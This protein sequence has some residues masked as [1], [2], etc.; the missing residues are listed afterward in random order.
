MPYESKAD[1]VVEARMCPRC[2]TML[3]CMELLD[4]SPDIMPDPEDVTITV[5]DVCGYLMAL[6]EDF[7]EREL[8]A[9]ERADIE[10]HPMVAAARRRLM[11]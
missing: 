10:R 2:C 3:N 9:K 11:H 1:I 8:T 6:N 4:E 5:C 7:S